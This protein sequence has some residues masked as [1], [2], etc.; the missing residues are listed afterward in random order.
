M[1]KKL[2]KFLF[3]ILLAFIIVFGGFWMFFVIVVSKGDY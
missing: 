3:S 2:A 1:L